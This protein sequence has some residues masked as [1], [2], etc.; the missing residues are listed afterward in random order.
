MLIAWIAI[1][2]LV[3]KWRGNAT[4]TISRHA[5]A[6]RQAYL[7]MGIIEIIVL[8]MFTIFSVKWVANEFDLPFLFSLSMVV[9]MSALL[10]AAWIPDVSGW[11]GTVHQICAYGSALLFLPMSLMIYR[12]PE[13]STFAKWFS[14]VVLI[15]MTTCLVGFFVTKKARKYSLYLQSLYI[16]LFDLSILAVVYIR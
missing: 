14:F 3:V 4:M 15:Y 6:Y 12:S 1:S 7:F 5:A 16:L 13:I 10:V 8:P 2:V 11:K 9:S